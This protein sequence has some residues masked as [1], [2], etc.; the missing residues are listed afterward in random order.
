MGTTAPYYC[1][2]CGN[3]TTNIS[4]PYNVCAICESFRRAVNDLA[5]EYQSE[6]PAPAIRALEHSVRL[7][8]DRSGK[9]LVEQQAGPLRGTIA[10]TLQHH[11]YGAFRLP[12]SRYSG[13]A[14]LYRALLTGFLTSELLPESLRSDMQTLLSE[15]DKRTQRLGKML[16]YFDQ[17]KWYA[18]PSPQPTLDD[19]YEGKSEEEA[20]EKL[21]AAHP[22]LK[23]DA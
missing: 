14:G 12:S 3:L 22:E 23:E 18:C 15:I 5:E 9:L 2:V 13:E 8:D 6:V 17:G 1:R 11:F 19:L 10:H 20:L 4:W 7:Y 16:T 21:Y